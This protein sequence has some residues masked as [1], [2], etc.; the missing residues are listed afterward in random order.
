V[1][2]DLPGQKPGA[3][4]PGPA[5]QAVS[6]SQGS[7]R[8][9]GGEQ[10]DMIVPRQRAPWPPRCL[11]LHQTSRPA[12]PSHGDGPRGAAGKSGSW[13]RWARRS[14]R[15]RNSIAGLADQRSSSLA[16]VARGAAA[17][18]AACYSLLASLRQSVRWTAREYRYPGIDRGA[19]LHRSWPARMTRHAMLPS[20]NP[21]QYGM[22]PAVSGIRHLLS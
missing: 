12:L 16:S 10:E 9:I 19:Q 15:S 5:S 22:T 7:P 21:E 14:S 6:R 1:Q 11:L 13:Q 20:R 4:A 18:R 8:G 17:D 2:L 3:C